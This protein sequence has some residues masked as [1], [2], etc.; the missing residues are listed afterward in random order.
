[1]VIVH[2][3][4]KG[5]GDER[6]VKRLVT[7]VRLVLKVRVLGAENELD[8]LFTPL[9]VASNEESNMSVRA[10]GEKRRKKKLGALF[11]DCGHPHLATESKLD[12][13]RHRPRSD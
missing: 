7:G 13:S 8:T 10:G 1:M 9:I 5:V 4:W 3:P 12:R 2:E 11:D 6:H